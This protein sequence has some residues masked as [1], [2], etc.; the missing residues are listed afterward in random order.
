MP[1]YP[2]G[3]KAQESGACVKREYVVAL[4]AFATGVAVC[5]LVFGLVSLV[6]QPSEPSATALTPEPSPSVSASPTPPVAPKNVILFIGDGMGI[7]TVTAARILEGQLRG[8]S[9]EDNVLSFEEFPVVALSKTYNADAQTPDS[10][11]TITALMSG[12][13]TD[14]G[15][16]NV[17]PDVVRASCSSVAGNEL[18]TWMMEAERAGRSTGVVSNSKL[19]DATPAGVYAVSPDRKWVHDGA[20]PA[21]CAGYPDIA[22]QL[23]SFEEYGDGLEVALGGGRN[24]FLPVPTGGRRDGRD[25]T[26]EWTAHGDDWVY[27]DQAS[28][29]DDLDLSSTTHLLGLFSVAEMNYEYDRASQGLDQ[30]TLTEM[31][32]AAIDQVK[33]D[34]DGFA[35][36]I[37]SAMIDKAHHLNNAYR[38][39]TETIELSNAVRAA[40]EEVD[41][42]N[43][44]II[45]TADHG[46]VLSFSGY[47]SLGNPILGVADLRTDVFGKPYTTLGYING[48]Y[49]GYGPTGGG[50]N[51]ANLVGVDTMSPS[52]HQQTLVKTVSETHSGEDVPL[53]AIG[54]DSEQFGGLREQNDFG[55]LIFSV[56]GINPNPV[57]GP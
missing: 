20:V 14:T 15:V 30:P 44:L 18:T 6:R 47:S 54:I 37:E 22:S 8:E 56:L 25:L 10:A 35:L 53:F 19:T 12:V 16:I 32:V 7:S 43:T 29:L 38:A 52:Y 36:M 39:L 11:S 41:L 57:Q 21:A 9:G 50:S 31:T 3:G 17:D 2:D 1:G 45:V 34:P 4:A 46:S 40:I 48:A 55:L 27:V 42:E 5:A 26:T 13:K 49:I 23:L 24:D 33:D 28:D 51:R